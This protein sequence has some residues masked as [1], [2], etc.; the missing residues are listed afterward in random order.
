MRQGQ[1]TLS[2]WHFV[3][4]SF[5]SDRIRIKTGEAI[6]KSRYALGPRAYYTQ[7][8]CFSVNYQLFC[9]VNMHISTEMTGLSAIWHHH[10]LGLNMPRETIQVESLH[11]K[12]AGL[13]TMKCVAKCLLLEGKQQNYFY[14]PKTAAA[15]VHPGLCFHVFLSTF[16]IFNF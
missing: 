1:C 3:P 7:G 11:E 9:E 14:V 2:N 4:S 12:C 13:N 10:L 8:S 5:K 6:K 16:S 15:I